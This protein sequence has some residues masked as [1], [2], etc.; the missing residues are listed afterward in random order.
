MKLLTKQPDRRIDGISI[1]G[2]AAGSSNAGSMYA[3]F[4]AEALELVDKPYDKEG[5]AELHGAAC[6]GSA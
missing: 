5:L 1:P 2:P 3:L 6:V 4:E